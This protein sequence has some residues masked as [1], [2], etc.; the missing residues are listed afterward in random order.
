MVSHL[1]CQ[2]LDNI[3]VCIDKSPEVIDSVYDS[4]LKI[5]FME[6]VTKIWIAEPN[7]SNVWVGLFNKMHKLPL[8]D[9]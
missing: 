9:F 4:I 5:Y 1:A 3:D 6:S 2:S 8:L 7:L